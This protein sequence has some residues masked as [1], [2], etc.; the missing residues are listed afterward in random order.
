[1]LYLLCFV[2][3]LTSCEKLL[4]KPD[5]ENTATGIF[6]QAWQYTKSHY[7]CFDSKQ[8]DW[9]NVYQTYSARVDDGMDTDSLHLVIHQMLSML[10]DEGIA[11]VGE[12]GTLRHEIDNS[13]YPS[14]LDTAVVTNNYTSYYND[15]NLDYYDHDNYT[16]FNGEVA[17]LRKF[18]KDNI[19]TRLRSI[20]INQ[21]K[22][23]IMDFRN[24]GPD[25]HNISHDCVDKQTKEEDLSDIIMNPK[26]RDREIGS[27]RFKIGAGENDYRTNK[28]KVGDSGCTPQNDY[29]IIIL[30]NRETY[31]GSNRTVY[32]MSKL[33]NVTV[34]GDRTGGGNISVRTF[35]LSN[36]WLLNIPAG[37]IFDLDGNSL[38]S[39]FDPDIFIND[40]PATTD[41]DEI[42]EKALELLN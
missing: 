24:L 17:Y 27:K 34:I 14:N 6:T 30:C 12:L 2:C 29:P 3:L 7:C 39:G 15:Y 41:K 19:Q 9:D 20:R 16:V 23:L 4:I 10:E 5:T 33:S 35:M 13:M 26:P 1:M 32:A 28:L 38:Q 25:D 8:V 11:I 18:S 22:G 42:I 37:T 40:D 31:G 36:G 21:Y